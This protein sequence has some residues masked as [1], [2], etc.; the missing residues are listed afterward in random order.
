MKNF[1]SVSELTEM[2]IEIIEEM[3]SIQKELMHENNLLKTALDEIITY[4]DELINENKELK[5]ALNKIASYKIENVPKKYREKS[6]YPYMT[7]WIQSIA[8]QTLRGE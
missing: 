5:D 4:E 2:S 8:E 3:L 7:G 6:P 1:E